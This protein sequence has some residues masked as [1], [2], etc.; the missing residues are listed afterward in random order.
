MRKK[1]QHKTTKFYLYVSDSI[2]QRKLP[3]LPEINHIC[4]ISHSFLYTQRDCTACTID[5]VL[6]QYISFLP[7]H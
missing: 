3:E 2:W 6:K 5:G 7:V 1:P 4:K